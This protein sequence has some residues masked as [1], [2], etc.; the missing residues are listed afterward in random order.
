VSRPRLEPRTFRIRAYSVTAMPTTRVGMRFSMNAP[1]KLRNIDTVFQWTA[2]M[3]K[4]FFAAVSQKLQSWNVKREELFLIS[5]SLL[6]CRVLS[7]LN[8]RLISFGVS[9]SLRSSQITELVS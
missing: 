8:T 4:E 5:S 7:S 1:I 9:L 2:Q 3:D 6:N